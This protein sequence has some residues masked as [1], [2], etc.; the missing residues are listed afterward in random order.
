M[1]GIAETYSGR[2]DVAIAYLGEGQHGGV[3]LVVRVYGNEFIGAS[4]ARIPVEGAGRRERRATAIR[5]APNLVGK[6]RLDAEGTHQRG[7][8]KPLPFGGSQGGVAGGGEAQRWDQVEKIRQ[9]VITEGQQ[10]GGTH[11]QPGNQQQG[12]DLFTPRSAHQHGHRRERQEKEQ[13]IH[14]EQALGV[15]RRG[16]FGRRLDGG[17]ETE[18]Q[19]LDTDVISPEPAR[20]DDSLIEVPGGGEQDHQSNRSRHARERRA[21]AGGSKQAKHPQ[22]QEG[23]QA[24]GILGHDPQGGRKREEQQ[25]AAALQTGVPEEDK[26]SSG[27]GQGQQHVR[28]A[29]TREHVPQRIRQEQQPGERSCPGRAGAGGPENE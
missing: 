4:Q 10:G 7:A 9:V 28:V 24:G 21:A 23:Q 5:E 1:W 27:E 20:V 3:E 29:E 15:E 13:R 19:K 22:D 2:V 11:Q 8:G 14:A 18:L 16:A 26:R 25:A 6:G 12:L 17:A